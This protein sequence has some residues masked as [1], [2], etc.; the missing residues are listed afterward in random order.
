MDFAVDN[1]LRVYGHVLVWHTQVPAWFFQDSAGNPL[2]TSEADKQLLRDR[3]HDHIFNVAQWI[4]DNYGTFGSDTNPVVG[5]DV[6]NEVV[7]DSGEFA[8]GLRRSEWYRILGEE[9]IHDAFE[10][11]DEAI[12]N[13]YAA[14]GANRPVK[15]FIN[16]YNTEQGGK[17][18]RY[19]AL[20]QRLLAAG[21]PVQGVG[22]QF[23]LS[24]N[25]P[26][27]SLAAAL[28][29]FADMPV[30]QAVTE[31]DVTV[32]TPVTQAR[33]I[34]QGHYYQD[35]FNVF[36]DYSAAD[37]GGLFSVTIWGLTDNRSWRSEQAPLIFD[38]ALQ[39]KPAY[40]G[41][42]DGEVPAIPRAANVFGG[43]LAL[44]AAAFT[45]VAWGQLPGLPA[46]QAGQFSLRWTP[47]HLTALVTVNSDAADAVALQ[48]GEQ[49][50]TVS[51]SA[52]GS[53]AI[54]NDDGPGWRAVV[55]VPHTGVAQGNTAQFDLRVLAGATVLGGW[56]SPGATGTLS[57]LEDLSFVEI[58]QA[59]RAPA[60]DGVID[61]V[62]DDA[63]VVR[64]TKRVEGSSNA[65][66]DVRTLWS[67]NKLYVLMQVDDPVIDLT[68]GDPW[69][70]DSVEIFIDRGNAKNG[71]YRDLDSQIRINAANVTSFGTGDAAL[72][73]SRLVS[74]TA[75]ADGGYIVEAAIDMVGT[76]GLGTFH[77]V[78]FQVNDGSPRQ[79]QSTGARTAVHTWA[80]PT[81]TGYQT[82]ARWGV[83]QFVGL[84]FP[85]WNVATVYNEGDMVV[86]NGSLWQASWWTQNT[87][88][89]S[90]T[91]PWQ[92][93]AYA[94]DG[95]AIWTA[96]RIFQAGEVVVY[97]GKRYESLWWTRNQT[98]GSPTGP[99]QEIATAENGTAIWTAS[100]VYNAGDVVAHNGQTYVAK[101]WT[102]NQQPGAANGPW[103]LQ[104]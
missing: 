91:G 39:A 62:W 79:G 80:E 44:N 4:S 11:A 66:A 88:P 38:G 2:G 42:I 24:L 43:D 41:A 97:N 81:G 69:Q 94:E 28:D 46:G 86:Y 9:Y 22:H 55:H 23:H 20:V 84:P 49:T 34:E 60:V 76:A 71:P 93:I 59:L 73:Q 98:P 8:D 48:Y 30:V 45:S 7:S 36:R 18:D 26:V 25:T 12:N 65:Q 75:L 19:Y 56:N 68:S 67:G 3:L 82:T 64:T 53:L 96:S 58:P 37:P 6:V 35:A 16:D 32:G 47:D 77:G 87:A 104:G 74:A 83:A 52:P 101:W 90:P 29:R 85:A 100:R 40:F 92:E 95:T 57:F 70:Q 15:L 27:S 54:I 13:V 51:K 5:F 31:L 50:V 78:D 89:G 33:L 99:W 1:D 102:R 14:P 63:N 61:P 21:V 10:W 72:Q 17:Q 103:Q